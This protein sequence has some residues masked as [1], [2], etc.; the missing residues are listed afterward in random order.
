M[1]KIRKATADDV[2]GIFNLAN[3]YAA[4]GLMLSR[5]KYKIISMLQCFIVAE[6]DTTSTLVGCGALS[7]LWTDLA[8]I[9]TLAVEESYRRQGIGSKIVNALMDEAI[10]LKVP[11]TLILTYQV[12]FFK[13]MG[14]ELSDKN[15]F[16][17]KLWREC[18][19]CPKLE[20]CDETVMHRKV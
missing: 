17:R 15:L 8:E 16:P 3:K 20:Q 2:D 12:D 7:L 1:I 19:E 5:S 4:R 14:F 9:M 10:Q 13:K 6:D 18:L 11:E